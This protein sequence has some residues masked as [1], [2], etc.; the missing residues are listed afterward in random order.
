[1]T[2]KSQ[3]VQIIAKPVAIAT[4]VIEPAKW[5]TLGLATVD[6]AI[7]VYALASVPRLLFGV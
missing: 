4:P 5:M 3:P 2:A 1:M 7:W 6:A